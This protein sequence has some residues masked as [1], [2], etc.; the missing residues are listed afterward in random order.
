MGPRKV[1]SIR[2]DHESRTVKSGLLEE[3]KGGGGEG[4]EERFISLP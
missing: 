1:N 2:E 4:E 3:E